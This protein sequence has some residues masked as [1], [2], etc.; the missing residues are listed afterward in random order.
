[1]SRVRRLGFWGFGFGD[2]GGSEVVGVGDVLGGVFVH[3]CE[4]EEN[5]VYKNQPFNG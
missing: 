4:M 3:G 1:M 2:R 5:V